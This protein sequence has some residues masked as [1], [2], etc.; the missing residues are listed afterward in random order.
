VHCEEPDFDRA[1]EFVW[2]QRI[3]AARAT[4][5]PYKVHLIVGGAALIAAIAALAMRRGHSAAKT[6]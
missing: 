1:G 4:L 6:V 5:R 3:A 2:K